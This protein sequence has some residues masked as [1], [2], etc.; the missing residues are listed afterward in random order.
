MVV[1]VSRIVGSQKM[2]RCDIRG[3][4]QKM[5]RCDIRGRSC[6]NIGESVRVGDRLL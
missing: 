2:N 5:N 4:S 1:V 3:R 6:G